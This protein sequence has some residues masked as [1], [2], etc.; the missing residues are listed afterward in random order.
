MSSR[1]ES[2]CPGK[3]IIPAGDAS[4]FI[5]V[6][7]DEVIYYVPLACKITGDKWI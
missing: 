7:A 4:I 1:T 3:T 2:A 5:I 6:M